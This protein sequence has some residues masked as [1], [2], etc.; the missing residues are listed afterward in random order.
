MKI[1]ANLLGPLVYSYCTKKES[2]MPALISGRKNP[3]SRPWRELPSPATFP[4]VRSTHAVPTEP[5]GVAMR[6]AGTRG[7]PKSVLR[8]K[9]K[10]FLSKMH[11]MPPIGDFG[12]F[13][14][15]LESKS[16]TKTYLSPE[17]GPKITFCKKNRLNSCKD[18]MEKFN[19]SSRSR[20][21]RLERQVIFFW[22]IIW[23]RD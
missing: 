12:T 9:C 15:S 17:C 3:L 1:N 14:P 10:Q 22:L 11:Y 20:V 23:H 4:E 21:T 7:L 6:V 8:A 2:S 5:V 13:P 19:L 18:S 16:S